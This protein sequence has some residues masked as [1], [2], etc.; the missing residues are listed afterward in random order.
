MVNIL[1]QQINN[2]LLIGTILVFLIAWNYK[3][4]FPSRCS[5]C[6]TLKYKLTTCLA[7]SNKFC[8]NCMA[9]TSALTPCLK[10]G[11]MF[12]TV[13]K[14]THKDIHKNEVIPTTSPVIDNTI[15]GAQ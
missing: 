11:S 9:T 5:Q 13:C 15:H 14:E 2:W 8:D 6:Y 4:I 12:C 3:R 1:G 7:C 10:C